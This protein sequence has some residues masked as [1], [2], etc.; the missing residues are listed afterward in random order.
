[1]TRQASAAAASALLAVA[2]APAGVT[3]LVSDLSITNNDFAVA[4][5]PGSS[6]I[7]TIVVGNAGPDDVVGAAVSDLATSSPQVEGVVWTCVGAGGGSCTAGPVSTNLVDTIDLPAGGTATYTLV[8][9]LSTTATGNLVNTATVTPPAGTTDPGPGADTATDTDTAATIVYVATTGIDSATCGPLAAPCKTIQT[10]IDNAKAGD[11]VVVAKGTYNECIVLVPGIGVG[12]V[13]V[14]SD[15]H[16]A[17][18]T[19]ASTILDGTGVCG[20]ASLSPGPVAKVYDRSSLLGF[21]IKGG[22]DS[23]VLG[24]GAISVVRNVITGNATAST[25]GGVRLTTGLNLSDALSKAEINANTI[26]T[27]TSGRD[28]AGIFV[29]ASASGIPSLVEIRGN[30]VSGNTAGDGTAGAK[31]SGISVLT[32]TASAADSSRVVITGNTLDGNVAKNST[33]DAT[34]ADGGGIFVATGAIGGAGT[35]TVAIGDA[36]SGNA[37]RNNVSD[38]VGG[39]MSIRVQPAPGGKHKVDVSAN[40]VTANTGKRG[41]GGAHLFV[42]A[43]DRI[44]G[45]APDL[46]LRVAANSFIRNHAQGLLSDPNSVGG[47]GIYAELHSDRT[48]SAAVLYE[49]SGNTIQGNDATTFG[50]GCSLLASADD[51]P[52]GD[53]ATAPA[54]AVISFHHNVVVQN[55]AHDTT[56]QGVSGGGV[57]ALA[58]ARGAA[59]LAR[60]SHDFLTVVDNQ[61]EL[62]SGGLEWEDLHVQNSLGF[63]GATSFVLSNSIISGNDGF[64]VGGTIVPGPSTTV[65][66]TYNDAF[67]NGS[68]D[69]EAQLGV[70]TGTNGN[71]SVDPELDALFLPRICGPMV[72]QA[73]PAIAATVE[74]QPNGG[75]VNLGHL[76]NTASATRTFPDVNGDGTIDGLDVLGIAVSFNSCSDLSCSD[77]TR[78]FTAADRDLNQ[79]VDGE[80]LAYVSAFYAQSC[81]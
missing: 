24:L 13:R 22:G 65:A 64:G 14:E 21:S 51:D 56:A 1:M 80:D 26:F 41:G 8:V 53:G 59:A 71:I 78:F 57:H 68:G 81:P 76:G 54:D 29:D 4:Y 58:V 3:A 75:R 60:V 36:G 23:G 31:G 38:G 10:G 73:D 15:E 11:T 62:G 44:A 32:D 12:G 70:I 74:P 9:T 72:D 48:A 39:G 49:I 43:V 42:Q 63:S 52:A 66:V 16:L 46:V 18:G 5:T 20:A 27:N 67:G 6:T 7:Y 77:H 37:I 79:K 55:A 28:G 69:Y 2:L 35:E 61:T 25:G 47:G 17:S 34:L 30:T 50:G 40:T 45:L 33:G 19:N